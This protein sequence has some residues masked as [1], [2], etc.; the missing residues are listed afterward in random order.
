M[1]SPGSSRDRTVSRSPFAIGGS[2]SAT[3]AAGELPPPPQPWLPFWLPLRLSA[4]LPGLG[5]SPSDW[6]LWVGLLMSA[7]GSTA[8][9]LH[10]S[11]TCACS[12]AELPK[13][14]SAPACGVGA[15]AG[16]P[17]AFTASTSRG[18]ACASAVAEAHNMLMHALAP[19]RAPPPGYGCLTVVVSGVGKQP[20]RMQSTDPQPLPA[21]CVPSWP[22]SS[23]RAWPLSAR[24]LAV[25]VRAA[26]SCSLCT[27]NR[28]QLRWPVL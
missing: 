1:A 20:C 7:P 27:Q 21:A 19:K 25:A 6:A 18:A 5:A 12:T 14:A 15:A 9:A 3:T 22:S 2:T 17:V 28:S 8:N 26:T 23:G 4:A 24:S 16:L 13:S 11:T 10:S